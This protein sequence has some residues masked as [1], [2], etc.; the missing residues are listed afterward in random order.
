MS[1][2]AVQGLYELGKS[3]ALQG[4]L[5]EADEKFKKVISEPY[6]Y[7]E[8]IELLYLALKSRLDINLSNETE[9]AN[10]MTIMLATFIAN[11]EYKERVLYDIAQCDKM[12]GNKDKYQ[13]DLEQIVINVPKPQPHVLFELGMIQ[14]ENKDLKNA[15]KNL[16]NYLNTVGKNHEG[17]PLAA[18]NL[19]T[20]YNALN[21]P[22]QAQK[23]LK[24]YLNLK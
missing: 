13:N 10:I 21:Q 19:A 18:L 24:R 15:S 6:I 11:T 17:A 7:D 8:D 5:K 2:A 16:V 22:D 14:F 3:L 20:C 1:S 9:R 23:V 12:L 4:N